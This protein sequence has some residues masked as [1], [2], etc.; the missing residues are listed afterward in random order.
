MAEHNDTG[1]AGEVLA[2]ELL[3]KKGYTIV[4]RNYKHYRY[5]ID[6]IASKNKTMVFVEVKTRSGQ[7]FG[8]PEEFVSKDQI[9]CIKRAAENFIF[10]S[11]WQHFVRFDVIA[12]Q[13]AG[14]EPTLKHFE[15]VFY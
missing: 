12:V 11:K 8:Y 2:A 1:K 4:R 5:E 7:Q 9:T 13:Y 14:N 3:E 15:D 6:L 10:S